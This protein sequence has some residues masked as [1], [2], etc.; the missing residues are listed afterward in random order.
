MRNKAPIKIALI[1]ATGSIGRSVVDICIR[2]PELF[3]LKALVAHSNA[4]SLLNLAQELNVKRIC[5]LNPLTDEFCHPNYECMSGI[6]AMD[7][8]VV[9]DDIDHVIFAS[10]GVTA[11]RALQLALKSNK[12]VSLANKESIVVGGPWVMPLVTRADQLRPIDSEHN[13]IWQCL[14]NEPHK[15]VEKIYLTASG[16]PFQNY[17]T[18]QMKHITP[19]QALN[20]PVWKMGKKVSIDSASLMN[21][22]IECIEATQLFNLPIEKIDAVIHPNSIAHGMVLFNDSTV[23][24]LLSEPDMRIPIASAISWPDRLDL[25]STGLVP[26]SLKNQSLNFKEIDVSKFPCY[27]LA[28]EAAA[29]GGAYPALLI[30]SDEVL[31]DSFINGEI[32]FLAIPMIID[33]LFSKWQGPSPNSLEDA[34]NLVDEA[35]SLTSDLIKKWRLNNC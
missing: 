4:A 29:A 16:G 7:E 30:G 33:L 15:E 12:D 28:L 3:Q 8:I 9:S 32:P 35:K 24:M 21:K 10:S 2:Y 13:A 23:K 34:I 27:K 14:K 20:H 5:L 18:E 1:G 22:G 6:K 26:L 19:E 31:V 17:T 11:I 25:I